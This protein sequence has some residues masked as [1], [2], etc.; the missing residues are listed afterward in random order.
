VVLSEAH[1]SISQHYNSAQPIST[2]VINSPVSASVATPSSSVNLLDWDDDHSVPQ[3]IAQ[4]AQQPQKLHLKE[5][6]V[7]PPAR[8]QQLWSALPEAFSGRVCHLT[9]VPSSGAEL[10]SH[11]RAEKVSS[12]Q[13]LL[14]TYH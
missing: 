4:P 6:A 2:G 1:T 9:S 10:E 13:D 7:I 8:F 3:N 11:L 12:H 14:Y 5:G